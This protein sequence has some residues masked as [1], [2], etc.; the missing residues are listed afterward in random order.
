MST[1]LVRV[2]VDSL[3]LGVGRPGGGVVRIGQTL[4]SKVHGHLQIPVFGADRCSPMTVTTSIMDK[5]LE[6]ESD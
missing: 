3:G 5:D 1:R 6:R 2:F 4:G